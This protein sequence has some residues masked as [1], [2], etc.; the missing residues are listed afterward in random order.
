MSDGATRT[1]SIELPYPAKRCGVYVI[2]C[3]KCGQKN[4]LTTA[5]RPDDPR[6]VTMGCYAQAMNPHPG[7]TEIVLPDTTK[8]KRTPH[9][10]PMAH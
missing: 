10:D 8:M 4:A 3:A 6:T 9:R 1:C 7:L 5:G 2:E